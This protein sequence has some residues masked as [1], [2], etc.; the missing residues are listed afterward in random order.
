MLSAQAP[1]SLPSLHAFLP[2]HCQM[3][4]PPNRAV[5]SEVSAMNIHD[6]YRMIRTIR[7][8]D[9]AAEIEAAISEAKGIC[10]LSVKDFLPK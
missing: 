2:V 9:T 10:G 1:R 7:T 8:N 4:E 6:K 3:D 5:S